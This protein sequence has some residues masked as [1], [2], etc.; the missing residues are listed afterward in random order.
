MNWEINDI[1]SYFVTEIENWS[2]KSKTTIFLKMAIF[3]INEKL[4]TDIGHLHWN[5][6]FGFE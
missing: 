6:S 1:L 2:W 5:G 3:E 4:E